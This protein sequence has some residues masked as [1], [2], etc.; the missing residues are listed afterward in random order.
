MWGNSAWTE[1]YENREAAFTSDDLDDAHDMVE[2]TTVRWIR[3]MLR[4]VHVVCEIWIHGEID[5]A[6]LQSCW[7]IQQLTASYDDGFRAISPC[8]TAE[9]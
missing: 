3:E 9:D 1:F 2:Q 7:K 8:F 5:N 4:F 6:V